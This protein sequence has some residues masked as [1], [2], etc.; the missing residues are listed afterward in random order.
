MTTLQ[1]AFDAL[2]KR[3]YFLALDLYKRL[4]QD[5]GGLDSYNFF[6]NICETRL[7]AENRSGAEPRGVITSSQ[8]RKIRRFN[9]SGLPLIS[10]VR[11]IGNN[12]KGLHGDRQ[13]L[14][15]LKRQLTTEPKNKNIQKIWVLNR[16]FNREIFTE[17]QGLLVDHDA[18]YFVIPYEQDIFV[19]IKPNIN[20]LQRYDANRDESD[21]FNSRVLY[22]AF[23]SHNRYLMNNNGARNAA[24]SLGRSFGRWV[25]PGDGNIFFSKDQFETLLAGLNEKS[26]PESVFTIPM[27]RE[28]ARERSLTGSELEQEPQLLVGPLAPVS[29]DERYAYGRR[30]K[31]EVLWRLGARGHWDDFKDDEFDFPR[32]SSLLDNF[33]FGD[34]SQTIRLSTH[35]ESAAHHSMNAGMRARSR[36]RGVIETLCLANPGLAS[37][38]QISH[39]LER[40]AGPQA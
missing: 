23:M 32:P 34:L 29:F 21:H 16:I 18:N 9:A 35:H 27:V 19:A 6:I 2:K 25:I 17:L 24:I 37:L 10:L 26:D 14:L 20:L 13:S 12:I 8:T 22:T 36:L 4:K 39:F 3:D 30:P 1:Q 28:D 15:N 38:S 40:T 5:K 7:A 11:V 31:V 33:Y